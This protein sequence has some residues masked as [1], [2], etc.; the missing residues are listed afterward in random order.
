M[1]AA[2][3]VA[4]TEPPA[5]DIDREDIVQKEVE[6]EAEVVPTFLLGCHCLLHV[7]P[8]LERVVRSL[9]SA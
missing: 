7:P 4:A 3:A 8:G 2:A 1:A 6:E 9:D 5:L